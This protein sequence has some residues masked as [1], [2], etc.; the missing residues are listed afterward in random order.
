M[1]G[2]TGTSGLGL[3]SMGQSRERGGA[4]KKASAADAGGGHHHTIPFHK[5]LRN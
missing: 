1:V 3:A 2:W 5:L 4:N